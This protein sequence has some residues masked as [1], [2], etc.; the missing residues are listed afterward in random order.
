MHFGKVGIF[1]NK[2]SSTILHN[3]NSENKY[4]KADI[5]FFAAIFL[6]YFSIAAFQ[7]YLTRVLRPPV[8]F[9]DQF[10][11]IN[12][13]ITQKETI[14]IIIDSFTYQHGPHRMGLSG[15][16]NNA[17]LAY[18]GGDFTLLNLASQFCWMI[19]GFLIYWYAVISSY[20]NSR[21]LRKH[22][23]VGYLPILAIFIVA[24]PHCESFILTG[25]LGHSTGSVLILIMIFWLGKALNHQSSLRLISVTFM[26]ICI[27]LLNY[28]GFGFIQSLVIIGI[29]FLSI[30]ILTVNKY[31]V[32]GQLSLITVWA[33][34]SFC[35][36]L[37]GWN[38]SNNASPCEGHM[39]ISQ[40]FTWLGA[41]YT[42]PFNWLESYDQANTIQRSLGLAT[43]LLI[44]CQ[45]FVQTL[46]IIR[47]SILGKTYQWF[48]RVDGLALILSSSSF[49]FASI[50]FIGRSCSGLNAAT[51]SRYQVMAFLGLVGLYLYL[52][53]LMFKNLLP[54]LSSETSK[55]TVSFAIISITTLTILTLFTA[56]A[57]NN[58]LFLKYFNRPGNG[59]AYNH[60]L[61]SLSYRYECEWA[62]DK[63]VFMTSCE[64]TYHKLHPSKK[65]IKIVKSFFLQSTPSVKPW[66]PRNIRFINN[67]D[68]TP[69]CDGCVQPS[70]EQSCYP[71]DTYCTENGPCSEGMGDCDGDSECASGL[72]CAQDVGANYGWN[73]LVDVCEQRPYPGDNYCRDNGPCSDG[74]GDCD[75]DSECVSGLVCAQDVGA[76][77]GWPSLV[78]VCEN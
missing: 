61:K 62:L 39:A 40:L 19:S 68:D 54:R 27:F 45:V 22:I 1:L 31:K 10:D 71:G 25:N 23:K 37:V 43:S 60:M 17:L 67:S 29:G 41:F 13:M 20:N 55:R 75:G 26:C 33:S 50:A 56:E 7:L 64:S 74:L 46:H 2:I 42:T 63:D 70:C 52:Y 11:F 51:S 16:I 34:L 30:L 49:L 28:T 8:P 12:P 24:A 35:A 58:I 5:V 6:V 73:P 69:G 36:F 59:T 77:Y 21:F 78:D 65:R 4:A 48:L 66:I 57:K 18:S 14:S 72:I 15:W 44:L 9:W 47:R 53:D 3:E 32:G 38:P 76:N